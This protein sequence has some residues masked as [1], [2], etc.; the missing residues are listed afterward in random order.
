M[1]QI[2]RKKQ[3]TKISEHEQ[4]EKFNKFFTD[5]KNHK[6]NSHNSSLIST[7]KDKP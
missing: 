7:S 5:F 1:L 4:R 2:D 6:N 3:G